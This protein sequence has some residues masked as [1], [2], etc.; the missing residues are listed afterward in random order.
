MLKSK[1]INLKF[2][3][4]RAGVPYATLN[5]YKVGRAGVKKGIDDAIKTKIANAMSKELN[6]FLN[7]LGFT[8]EI[9]RH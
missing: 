9:N 1:L 5:N 2:L 6:A 3:A 7:D 8:V 4:E